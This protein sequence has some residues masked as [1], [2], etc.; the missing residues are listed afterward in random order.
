MDAL[1]AACVG[2]GLTLSLLTLRP[3]R[4]TLRWP[5][6][7]DSYDSNVGD[8][9]STGCSACVQAEGSNTEASAT[10]SGLCGA[11]Q[12]REMQS[13]ANG[14]VV[15]DD[16][17]KN[18][19]ENPT[20][21]KPLLQE[22][23]KRRVMFVIA[24]PDDECMF[25]GPS[26]LHFTQKEKAMVYLVC[27]TDGSYQNRALGAKRQQE[28]WASCKLLGIPEGHV[29]LYK[30][31]HIPD[32]PSKTW[33]IV[34][35]ANIINNHLHTLNCDMVITFDSRGVSGHVNHRSLHA[36]LVY[37]LNEKRLPKYCSA[38][39]L[40]SVNMVRKYSSV[41]DIAC[42]NLCSAHVLTADSQQFFTI[43]RAMKLHESQYVW[44]R[45]LYI[46]FSRYVVVNTLTQQKPSSRPYSP[47]VRL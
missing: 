40:D 46:I 30:C 15:S 34:T 2:L 9:T 45:K 38:Y 22:T 11:C 5:P 13:S 3:R 24:H 6:V 8:E 43:R 28:L 33:P 37:L 32:D 7:Q 42:S 14:D 20:L 41:L 21:K 23:R 12:T 35:T 16:A 4:A 44:F 29:T 36:A 31:R 26:I 18:L 17:M 25:F 19:S 47:Y 10:T 1:I 27:M 39:T